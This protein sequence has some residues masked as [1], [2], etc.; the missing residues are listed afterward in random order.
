MCAVLSSETHALD[1]QTWV[2]ICST[3]LNGNK[4]GIEEWQT[5]TERQTEWDLERKTQAGRQAGRR[6]ETDR[7]KV[8][9]GQSDA[10]RER[11]RERRTER[12]RDTDKHKKRKS[13]R[14]R[15]STTPIPDQSE[16]LGTDCSGTGTWQIAKRR[17]KRAVR[18]R[19]EELN[20]GLTLQT[21]DW[22]KLRQALQRRRHAMWERVEASDTIHF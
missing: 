12:C 8:T 10:E 17:M 16:L 9:D 7:Y 19:G 3:C 22:C 18:G 11:E 6:R 1:G 15:E 4:R 21:H 2:A 5:D 13:E 20:G 14:E